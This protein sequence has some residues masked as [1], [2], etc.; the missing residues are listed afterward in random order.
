MTGPLLTDRFDTAFSRARAWHAEQTRKGTDIPY[1]GHLMHVSAFVIEAA[2]TED[3][4]IAALLHDAL[5]DADDMAA[6]RERR[7][8][9]ASEFGDH[10]LALVDGCTDGSPAEKRD[11]TW[12]ERKERHLAHLLGADRRLLAVSLADKLHNASAILRD[13]RRHGPGFFDNLNASPAET[14]WYYRSLSTVFTRRLDPD[15]PVGR[16]AAELDRVVTELEAEVA[17]RG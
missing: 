10:V 1:L 15:S 16:M 2:G 11:L 9:I 7:E 8:R 14:A 3:Q 4:A 5:E 12:H 6:Y 17:G 13:L